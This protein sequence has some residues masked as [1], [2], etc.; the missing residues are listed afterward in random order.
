MAGAKGSALEWALALLHAPGERHALR[1]KPLPPGIEELLAIAGGSPEALAHAARGQ[2]VDEA[3][4]R[5][6]ARFYAREV[7]F[8]PQ[9]DAYRTLGVSRDASAEQIKAHHRLLQ[10]WLHPDRLQGD[11]DAVFAGRVNSA[12]NRLRSPERR[13]AYDEALRLERP[14]EVFDSSDTPR[15]VSAWEPMGEPPPAGLQR[16]RHRVPG[17]ALGLACLVLA[18]MVLQ[19]MGQRPEAWEEGERQ[20]SRGRLADGL[21]LRLPE[22]TAQDDSAGNPDDRADAPR[23]RR[24]DGGRP[25]SPRQVARGEVAANA[26]RLD[27][28]PRPAVANAS[29]PPAIA[30][31]APAA[32][33]AVPAPAAPAAGET[34]AAP[35]PSATTKAEVAAAGVPAAAPAVA[36]AAPVTRRARG[37]RDDEFARMQS[38][39]EVGEQL[40]RY[41]GAANHPPPPIWNSPAIQSSAEQLRHD[42]HEAGPPALAG[43]KWRIGQENAVLT[44][45]FNAN[46]SAFGAVTADLV[47]RQ[48]H[49]LVTGVSVERFE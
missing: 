36:A 27:D 7:L 11:D 22:R 34:V 48:G 45:R 49:W 19:D 23:P 38:A 30:P 32:L 12:W 18:V 10:H 39:R 2:G 8:F 42:L 16:W 44:S 4:L 37:V 28:T 5:E 24:R 1:A 46:A 6:A 43:P 47:W 31:A 21:G 14:P 33:A 17:L 29:A 26:A 3:G 13:A 9:A 20:P 35:S 41:M 25:E 15:A 40:L